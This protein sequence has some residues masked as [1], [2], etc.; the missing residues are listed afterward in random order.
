[1]PSSFENQLN[2]KEIAKGVF[3]YFNQ[4]FY[5]MVIAIFLAVLIPFSQAQGVFS[6]LSMSLLAVLIFE[7]LMFLALQTNFSP[8]K[9]AQYN[10]NK[11]SFEIINNSGQHS[12]YRYADVKAL[13]FKHIIILCLSKSGFAILA[14]RQM[15]EEQI[16]L[17]LQ[18]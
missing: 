11:T 9:T 16:N 6:G 13:Q 3:I 18:K 7:S 5:P 1:M 4:R 8:R 14:K 10:L 17:F 15:N 2:Y 12:S